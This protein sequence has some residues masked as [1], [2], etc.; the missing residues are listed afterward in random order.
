METAATGDAVER[1][2]TVRVLILGGTAESRTLAEIVQQMRG[3]EAISSLAG[4][5]AAPIEPVGQ[6]RIGGF[7]GVDALTTWLRNN[8]I[9]AVVDATHPYAATMSA[10]AAEA[11]RSVGVPILALV[12]PRW[13]AQEGD[14][15]ST[16]SSIAEAASAIDPGSRVFL[17]VGRQGVHRFAEIEHSWFLIR[18]IDAPTGPVPPRMTLML[19][20]G[21]FDLGDEEAILRENRIDLLITKNSGGAM[22]RAK[23]DAARAASVPVLVVDRPA[24][25]SAV[26]TVDD[27]ASAVEWLSGQLSV[28]L[29]HVPS[30]G[31]N[32]GPTSS[33]DNRGLGRADDE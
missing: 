4:R 32:L 9:D 13:T 3:I 20:R 10:R 26:P 28:R 7:G 1:D 14:R 15:W 17:T 25:T 16:V 12:R 11:C 18:A 24:T 30:G 21:P 5:V 22:T 29:R 6:V 2:E 23:L 33:L 19:R 27:V 8:R 31:E